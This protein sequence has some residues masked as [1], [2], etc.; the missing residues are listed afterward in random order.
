MYRTIKISEIV[1]FNKGL[2]W[3][4]EYSTEC[5]G[6]LVFTLLMNLI[7]YGFFINVRS[8]WVT[9]SIPLQNLKNIILSKNVKLWL[10]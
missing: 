1:R 7:L 10:S 3:N 6:Q 9:F 2:K 8:L 5:R 4:I